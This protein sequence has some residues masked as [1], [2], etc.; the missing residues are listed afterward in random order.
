VQLIKRFLGLRSDQVFKG[1]KRIKNDIAKS[2]N[3]DAIVLFHRNGLINNWEYGFLQDTRL[4]RVLSGKQMATRIGIN[5]RVLAAI[6]RRG[7]K[8]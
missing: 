8:A 1:I 7:L 5:E 6:A 4:K 3:A 2:L